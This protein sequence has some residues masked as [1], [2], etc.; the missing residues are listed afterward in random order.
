MAMGQDELG[1]RIAQAREDARLT[2]RDLADKVGLADPQ[3][4]SN[5]ERGV[6][7]VPTKKLRRIAEATKKPMSYFLGPDDDPAEPVEGQ[8]WRTQV[9]ERMRALEEREERH[10]EMLHELLTLV[11][12]GEDAVQTVDG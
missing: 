5:Y 8:E 10:G 4:V 11:R 1:R 12:G 7:E 2:Q 9:L 6:T 3:S